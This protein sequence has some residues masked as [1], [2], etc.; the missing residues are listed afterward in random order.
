MANKRFPTDTPLL[1]SLQDD[2]GVLVSNSLLSHQ[3][4]YTKISIL[5]SKIAAT[6]SLAS[7][8][9]VVDV[10]TKTN[11][12]A[13]VPTDSYHPST[14]KYVDDNTLLRTNETAFTPTLDYH[15]ATKKYVDDTTTNSLSSVTT[16]VVSLSAAIDADVLNL[17]NHLSDVSN[18][19]VV[20]ASQVGALANVVEDTTPQLGGDLDG[21]GNIVSDIQLQS[22]TETSLSAASSSGILQLDYS[23]SNIFTV[24][25]TEDTSASFINPPAT[26]KVGNVTVQVTQDPA[27]PRTLV[28]VGVKWDGGTPPTIT[29]T[30]GAVDFFSFTTLDGGANW[31]GFTTG[32]AMA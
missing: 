22:Y 29:A 12:T 26:G 30:I 6:L 8:A 31:Y 28:F 3:A 4:S 5:S 17:S 10:L 24:T 18:P 7:K 16:D 13:Y 23:L 1:S 14:K 15:P 2:D 20:T 21:Q 9:N 19:H 25:L 32:Q 27:T 11:V